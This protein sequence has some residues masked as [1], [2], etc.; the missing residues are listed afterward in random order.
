MFYVGSVQ[1]YDDFC[2]VLI[3]V[4]SIYQVMENMSV[5]RVSVR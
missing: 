2:F 4:G 5:S 1:V 3:P